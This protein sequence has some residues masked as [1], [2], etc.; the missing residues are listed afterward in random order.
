MGAK[1][2]EPSKINREIDDA[3]VALGFSAEEAQEFA[4]ILVL[5]SAEEVFAPQQKNNDPHL[6]GEGPGVMSSPLL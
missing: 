1:V 3:V 4:R 6:I 2:I 5:S